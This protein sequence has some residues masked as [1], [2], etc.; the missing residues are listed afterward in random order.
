MSGGSLLEGHAHPRITK[1]SKSWLG[2]G[3]SSGYL[4]ASHELLAR[5][6]SHLFLGNTPWKRD[7]VTWIFVDSSEAAK[8]ALFSLLSEPGSARRVY[9]FD[10]SDM[11]RSVDKNPQP[12]KGDLVFFRFGASPAECDVEIVFERL[13]ENGVFIATDE[14]EFYSYLRS[15]AR[16]NLL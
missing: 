7:E 14:T 10:D 12:G 4:S 5:R 3:I 9:C 6:L 16:A 1:V 13:Y 2:R 11:F 8:N 15:R